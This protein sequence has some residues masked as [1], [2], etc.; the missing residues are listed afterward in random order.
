MAKREESLLNLAPVPSLPA[1]SAHGSLAPFEP[2]DQLI[3]T[4]QRIVEQVKLQ[5]LLQNG[6]AIKT[7]YGVSKIAEVKRHGVTTFDDTVEYIETIRTEGKRGQ[8]H[9]R[10]LDEFC[11]HSIQ[12]LAHHSTATMETG[13]YNIAQIVH[14]PLEAPEEKR[15]FWKRLFGG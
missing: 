10:Y 12:T 5:T 4:E 14:R 1:M 9:Q 11:H 6:V 3:R 2:S 7:I 13:A 8:Q 15:G